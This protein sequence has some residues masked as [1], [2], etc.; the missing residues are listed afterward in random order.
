MRDAQRT[1]RPYVSHESFTSIM[2]EARLEGAL[3]P[4]LYGIGP[5]VVLTTF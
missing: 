5:A 2:C 4:Q 3:F 1:C